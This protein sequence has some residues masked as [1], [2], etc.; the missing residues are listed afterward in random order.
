M[1][2]EASTD[3]IGP[4]KRPIARSRDDLIVHVVDP[5][6]KKS[7]ARPAGPMNVLLAEQRERNRKQQ[8]LHEIRDEARRRREFE[9]SG[10]TDVSKLHH[11]KYVFDMKEIRAKAKGASERSVG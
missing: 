8:R 3:L 2:L 5:D 11:E 1:K 9:A 4:N 6:S 7:K 10:E